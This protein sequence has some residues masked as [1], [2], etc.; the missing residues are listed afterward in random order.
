VL[1]APANPL[2]VSSVSSRHFSWWLPTVSF[3]LPE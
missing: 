3:D 2:V 1:T